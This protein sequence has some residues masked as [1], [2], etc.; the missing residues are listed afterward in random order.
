MA[1]PMPFPSRG[2]RF[3]AGLVA[4]VFLFIIS[5]STLVRFYTDLLWYQ[6]VGFDQVFW[7]TLA[8]RVM[9]V[10]AFGLL[11]FLFCLV[12]LLIVRRAAPAYRISGD[13]DD[14]LERF[15]EAFLPYSRW[16]P[17]GI[18]AFL[19]LFFAFRM[20]PAWREFLLALNP[21]SFGSN[22]PIFGLDLSFFMFRLPVY[23]LLYGWIFSALLVTT[24]VVTGSY[25]LSG[26]IRPQAQIERV[27]PQ[28]KAHL[29]VLIG[30]MALAR[31]WGY[32]LNQYEL[33]YSPRGV[34]SGASY[35]DVNAEL[36]ALKLLVAISVISAALFLINIRFRGWT[37]PLTAVGLWLLTSVLAAGVFPFIVQRF[38][39]EPAELQRERPFI[40]RNISATRTAFGL[41]GIDIR[42]FPV[43][44]DLGAQLNEGTANTL[45]NVRLWDPETLKSAFRQL[46]EIRTYYAF[47]D[48]DVDRYEIDG[49]KRQVMLSLR[50]LDV[51]GLESRT[52]QNDHIVFTHGYGA[53]A[54]P[55]NE[56]VGEGAPLL[57]LRD[58][59]P[60]TEVEGLSMQQARIY[61]GE[62]PTP[63][64]IVRTE[65]PELDY[66]AFGENRTTNYAG[67]S[68]VQLS[69]IARRLA[70]AWR[71]RDVNLAISGL[72]DSDSKV[73]FNRQVRER[74][75]AAA[76]FLELDGDAY[77]VIAD[78]RV[79]WML[80]AYTVSNKYPYGQSVNFAE[81]TQMRGPGAGSPSIEGRH[82][83]IRNS[84]KATVD[85]YDG[86]IR[87][88]VWDEEDPLI[89]SWQRT[90][91]DLFV[92]Q[93]EMPASLRAH[94][95]F[96][97]DLFRLQTFIYQRYHMTN[98]TDFYQREDQWVIPTDPSRT[99]NQTGAGGEIDPYY[100]LMRL[101]GSDED[102]YKLILPMNPRNRPNMVSLL[103]AGSDPDDFG[104]LIDFRFP[105]GLQTFGVGQVNSRI[106]ADERISQ[107]ITLL[108]QTGSNVILG[109]LLVIPVGQ[110]ILYTQPL[111]LQADANAI[112]ELKYVIAVSAQ[113][114]RGVVMAPTLDEAV[115]ALVGEGPPTPPPPP[116][117]GAPPVGPQP[118][119]PAGDLVTEALN[120][121]NASEQAAR[122]GDWATYGRE[123]EAARN[124]L[125]QAVEEQ[126]PAPSPSPVG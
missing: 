34:V 38:R 28:V 5:I 54:S 118:T 69:N 84:V 59:P 42:E 102:E 27:S 63:Y 29:S 113:G 56:A 103:M 70:F 86:T 125:R 15:R 106:N 44:P 51:G 79:F 43:D 117:G 4:F 14:P 32:R 21:V 41:R 126:A 99:A 75:R 61:F 107:T 90:F 45:D 1:T 22:D 17:V 85:A 6:E 18:S 26:A 110:S 96:P 36:P 62:G 97:E 53:V 40:Q 82:N 115:Q 71:F 64:S 20:G 23:E 7:K 74:V 114:S 35:T 67:R 37:L 3:R 80:D 88:Y 108:D 124:A 98:P 112:P 83:Y 95:R 94:I 30:L 11:F 8:Y 9:L 39:V 55:T 19:A 24:L 101:P 78:G 58:I 46:Q 68:G 100:V 76:P 57:L 12:N 25:Y 49:Q 123:L 13:Q 33:L 48:V 72:I 77:P 93:A 92:D 121:L 109:N 120:R 91:P 111:F 104:S 89:R 2:R 66:T 47:Q 81:R 16:I 50:E 10:V 105:P 52:W 122:N 65:Q 116:T 31:A 60:N 73:I 87:L 119:Q